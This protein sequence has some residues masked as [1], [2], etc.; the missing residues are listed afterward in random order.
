MSFPFN[1]LTIFLSTT[2]TSILHLLFFSCGE[3]SN[4]PI[5]RINA[6]N[7]FSK[8]SKGKFKFSLAHLQQATATSHLE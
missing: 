7:F 5:N 4:L 8:T 6:L 3:Y 2:F 1:R